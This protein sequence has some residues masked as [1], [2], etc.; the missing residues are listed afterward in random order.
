MPDNLRTE[1]SPSM[2]SLVEGIVSDAQQLVRQEMSLARAEIQEEWHKMKS[3]AG[4]LGAGIV[5][6][7]LSGFFLSV[8]AVHLLHWLT[9]LPLWACYGIMGGACALLG[10]GLIFVGRSQASA[11]SFVPRQTVETMRENVQWIRN[12]T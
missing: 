3:A 4:A 1:E 6:L 12:Q 11:V 10:A 9:Q 7:S 5:V 2:T 8:M